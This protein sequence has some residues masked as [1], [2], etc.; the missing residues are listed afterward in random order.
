MKIIPKLPDDWLPYQTRVH[1]IALNAAIALVAYG[2]IALLLSIIILLLRIPDS[3]IFF[4]GFGL[5]MFIVPVLGLLVI[6]I[7]TTS[8]RVK[9]EKDH[10][11]PTE[12]ADFPPPYEEERRTRRV[13]KY[14]LWNAGIT[15]ALLLSFF[16]VVEIF[17]HIPQRTAIRYF[18]PLLI[19]GIVVEKYVRKKLMAKYRSQRINNTAAEQQN[20]GDRE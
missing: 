16:V 2:L 13:T 17:Y 20:R 7:T 1:R 9:Y 8:L 15:V 3:S 5:S 11:V 12:L 18:I 6:Y 14:D 10:P 4:D 19:I